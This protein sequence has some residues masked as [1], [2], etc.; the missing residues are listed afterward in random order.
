MPSGRLATEYDTFAPVPPSPGTA[1]PSPRPL[2]LDSVFN[3]LRGH[4]LRSGQSLA[5]RG[6]PSLGEDPL[7]PADLPADDDDSGIAFA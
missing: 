2:S 5:F 1:T 3:G 4:I 7:F 6:L